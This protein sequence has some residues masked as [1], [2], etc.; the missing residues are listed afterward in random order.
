MT[1]WKTAADLGGVRNS[2]A[3]AKLSEAERE[4]WRSLWADV[5]SLLKRAGGWTP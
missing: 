2:E 4:E 3:L 5:E 1:Q